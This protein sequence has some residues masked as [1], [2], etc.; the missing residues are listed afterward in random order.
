M[1]VCLRDK[2]IVDVL[3]IFWQLFCLIINKSCIF[4]DLINCHSRFA[5]DPLLCGG[6]DDIEL[7]HLPIT[8][9]EIKDPLGRHSIPALH[10]FHTLIIDLSI[11]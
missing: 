8:F 10:H 9:E 6:F 5:Q 1:V 11:Q 7:R 2:I 3:N 4:V